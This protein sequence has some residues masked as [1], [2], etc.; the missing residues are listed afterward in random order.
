[1]AVLAY[2]P[3]PM[4][5]RYLPLLASGESFSITGITESEAG[6]KLTDIRTTATPDGDGWVLNGMKTEVHIPEHVQICL[7]F[8]MAPAGITAFLVD[9]SNRGFRVV[10]QRGIVGL[11]GLP[12]SA[13]AFDD[14]RVG[15]DC[16]LGGEGGAY[17]VFF[18]SFDLTRIGNAAK[19]IGIARGAIEDAI[20][21]ASKRRI[22]DNVV[23]DFQGI[24]WQLADFDTRLEAARLLTF[25]A[26]RE[27]EDTG[28]STLESARA[29]LLASTT[30]MEATT[31]ALQ[32][33]GSHGCFTE[34]A[35]ARY[36]MDAKIS[37]ITGGTIEI[38]RNTIA[39]EI[40]G[41]SS[42]PTP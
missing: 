41:K 32:I 6:S 29:K 36:M 34:S 18:K 22:G 40:L 11:R 35:F 15:N 5:E 37:Q 14:C 16:L 2:A 4:K 28:R 42:H 3:E 31:A 20:A 30:A 13:I 10:T 19:C 8:A 25:K 39:R 24:R 9:T 21:Y 33:T 23:T 27:Y 12:M 17:Q 26:A 38:L 1:M 7:M